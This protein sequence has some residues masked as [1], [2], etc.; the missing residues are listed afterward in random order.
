MELILWALG[1]LAAC[2]GVF[3]VLAILVIA[4]SRFAPKSSKSSGRRAKAADQAT[5]DVDY[6]SQDAKV[7]DEKLHRANK[8]LHEEK[9]D[10]VLKLFQSLDASE[11][12]ANRRTAYGWLSVVVRAMQRKGTPAAGITDAVMNFFKSGILRANGG[13]VNACIQLLTKLKEPLAIAQVFQQLHAL[14]P[15][16]EADAKTYGLVLAVL[17]ESEDLGLLHIL[18]EKFSNDDE[19]KNSMMKTEQF[20]A[21]AVK[22]CTNA[23]DLVLGEH[24][25]RE[26]STE[27]LCSARVLQPL[28]S[29]FAK[30][31]NWERALA[32]VDDVQLNE[33]ITPRVKLNLRLKLLCEWGK[34]DEVQELLKSEELEP[35][36]FTHYHL[37]KLFTSK[38]MVTEAE[39][40]FSAL[41]E[42]GVSANAACYVTLL[43]LHFKKKQ[44]DKVWETFDLAK[45]DGRLNL[46]IYAQMVR[47]LTYEGYLQDAC[48]LF[49]EMSA[50]GFADLGISSLLVSKLYEA[51][52]RQEALKVLADPR[53]RRSENAKA[54]PVSNFMTLIRC[55]GNLG[56]LDVA[57]EVFEL[58]NR[59]H[60]K[61]DVLMY[62]NLLDACV[63]CKQPNRAVQLLKRMHQ[64]GAKPDPITYNTLIRAYAQ[65]GDLDGAFALLDNMAS[66]GVTPNVVTFNS[67]V[68][69]AVSNN[70]ADKA[71]AVLPMMT[72]VGV[73]PDSVTFASLVTGIKQDRSGASLDRG[74]ECF[75]HLKKIGIQPD[76]VFFNSLMD[77]CVHFGRMN[78]ASEVFSMMHDA[79]IAPTA[80][81]YSVLMKGHGSRR[82]LQGALRVKD[83]MTAAGVEPNAVV[84]GCLADTALKLGR[85]DVAQ[86]LMEEMDSKGVEST[87]VTYSLRIKLFSRQRKLQNAFDVLDEME[88]KS[89]KPSAVTFNSLMDAVAR[90]REMHH[91]P[92]LLRLIKRHG[93]KPD[94]ITFSTICKGYC[95]INDLPK[96]FETFEI[97]Q[98]QGHKPDEILFN[99]LLDGCAR[100]G[101]VD[102]AL[103]LIADMK[104]MK[105]QLS[106]VTFS[107]LVKAYSAAKQVDKAF[108][109]L[110]EAKAAGVPPGKVIY[111]CLIQAC[112]SNNQ[113]SRA[114][115]T[116][117]AMW[118][119]GIAP[120]G[121]TFGAIIAG[122]VQ[123][124]DHATGMSLIQ[125]AMEQKV[126]LTSKTY[127]LMDKSLR[128][129]GGAEACSELTQIRARWPPEDRVRVNQRQSTDP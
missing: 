39:K 125:Q 99:S 128:R 37:L 57:I 120:D 35:D 71:W 72:K 31:T 10:K 54:C 127:A 103:E 69:A 106:N 97:L 64:M 30:A 84:Y 81:T 12:A 11:A 59:I 24:F 95:Q 7:Q 124:G 36:E 74:F 82:D 98:Q 60:E 93:V 122:C 9:Y 1:E 90:C 78:K 58:C 46:T 41:R 112:T 111:T 94:L 126:P 88:A 40:A 22:C 44:I 119:E 123:E 27:N 77:T 129:S 89:L 73:C 33:H 104:R 76:E 66:S 34:L 21:Q 18:V 75:T 63:Q 86:E 65:N 96:A 55:A 83:E 2:A 19:L 102:R 62:N 53:S 52:H 91:V 118:K 108:G 107:I 116:F 51:K 117:N 67:L 38:G 13:S 32:V 15:E 43:D 115:E 5:T 8:M 68:H 17:A 79:G 6:E 61:V 14:Y 28:L 85:D 100:V 109:V 49:H 92:K 45:T 4:I 20:Y 101:D 114:I 25:A 23:G 29:G 87:V 113:L 26:S 48:R 105:L 3:L 47:N 56:A 70:R 50:A 16:A 121:A 42:G 80:V 110:D